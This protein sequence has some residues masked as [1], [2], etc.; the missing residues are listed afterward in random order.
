MPQLLL[1][2]LYHWSPAGRFDQIFREGLRPHAGPTVA[3]T[4]SLCY[5]C[6]SPTPSRAWSLS[7][8]ME[9]VSE[10]DEW[11]LWQ[12]RLADG[13]DVRIRPDYGPAIQ[14]VKVHGPIPADRIWWAARRG[15]SP[16]TICHDIPQPA[17]EKPKRAAVKKR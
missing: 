16:A 15:A 13:D 7:G 3:G 1:P 2:A 8:D 5:V 9:W 11:D 14:E 12:V 17:A 6:L 4:T 10:F